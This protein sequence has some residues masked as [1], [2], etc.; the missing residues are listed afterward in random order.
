M[1]ERGAWS[2][3]CTQRYGTKSRVGE[4]NYASS[5]RSS[6]LKKGKL[7]STFPASEFERPR[8]SQAQMLE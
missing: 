1:A 8:R 3:T 5:P 6:S 7:L 4:R 2:R